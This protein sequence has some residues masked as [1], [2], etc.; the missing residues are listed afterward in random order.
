MQIYEFNVRATDDFCC[1]S[2]KYLLRLAV[3]RSG[4][5]DVNRLRKRAGSVSSTWHHPEL[6][7]PSITWILGPR[8]L[9]HLF[10]SKYP[11]R[12]CSSVY[13]AVRYESPQMG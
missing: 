2:S 11:F 13:A 3:Y 1:L 6:Y 9:D 4:T 7:P 10:D 12:F 8:D 5:H